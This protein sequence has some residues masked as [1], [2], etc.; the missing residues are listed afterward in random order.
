MMKQKDKYRNRSLTLKEV[1]PVLNDNL[2]SDNAK[3][4]FFENPTI[5]TDGKKKPN[6]VIEY[7][8]KNIKL[9]L[10]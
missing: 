8:G 6:V 7:L 9:P 10:L 5:R 4:N 3:A 2:V 1:T